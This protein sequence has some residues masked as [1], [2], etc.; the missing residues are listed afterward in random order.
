MSERST[1][2][3]IPT[4]SD[5]FL[6]FECP[7]CE[8]R[9]KLAA[10]EVQE[11]DVFVLHCPIC[12]LNDDAQSFLSSGVIEAAQTAAMNLAYDAINEAMKGW[13]RRSRSSDLIRFKAG[14]PLKHEPEK[15]LIEDEAFELHEF[16]CCD[17]SAKVQPIDEVAGVYCPYCGTAE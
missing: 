1:Q 6:S 12:G 9:F 3:S 8:E 13:E 4:D 7:F 15:V 5:G 16:A 10:N 17:R 11:D 14:S 2:I